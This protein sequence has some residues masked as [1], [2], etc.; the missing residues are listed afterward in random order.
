MTLPTPYR[1]TALFV[2]LILAAPLAHLAAGA[3]GASQTPA[4][5]FAPAALDS[6]AIPEGDARGLLRITLHHSG[7]A[8]H[9]YVR[10]DNADGSARYFGI[11]RLEPG[12]NTLEY[13][14]PLD[15]YSLE[16]QH[17]L[18]AGMT[19]IHLTECESGAAEA[20]MRTSFSPTRSGIKVEKPRCLDKGEA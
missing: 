16:V 7:L 9:V 20:V 15:V 5:D 6:A 17:V 8:T 13:D 11:V 12:T 1:L 19:R 3:D 10:G 14:L 18:F 4:S 2:A